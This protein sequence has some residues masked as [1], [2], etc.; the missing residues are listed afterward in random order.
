[1][2]SDVLSRSEAAARKAAVSDV[3][4]RLSLDLVAGAKDYSGVATV[5]FNGSADTFLEFLG[6]AIESM[7]INGVSQDP[8]WDGARIRLHATQLAEA[9]EITITYRKPYDHSGEGFHQF[10]DPNDGAEYLY[11]QFEPYGAHRLFP[12]FDQ[13][14]LKATYHLTVTAPEDWRIISSGAIATQ[15]PSSDGRIVTTFEET[16]PFSTYLF[17]VIAGAWN[18]VADDHNGLPMSLYTRRS[19]AEFID[20][21]ELFHITKAGMEFFGEF[22]GRRYPFTKYD[23]MFV[24]EFNW[25]G[26][27]NVAAV[28]YSDTLIFRDPP[29]RDQRVRRAE[30][31]LHELAHMWF[32]DLVTM[33]WWNDLWLNESFATFAAYLAIDDT[34]EWGESWQDFN[35][36]N[37]LTAYHD[38]QQ[39]T[40]H[41]IVAEVATTDE[42]FLNFDMITYGKGASTL[43]QLVAT[44]GLDAFSKGLQTYFARYE[45]RNTTLADFLGALQEGSGRQLAYWASRWLTTANLNTLEVRWE[46]SGDLVS[47]MTLH[48]SAPEDYPTL[49]PHTVEVGL[50]SESGGGFAVRGLPVTIDDLEEPVPAAVGAA[51][52]AA[53][54]PNY[55][56]LTYAKVA[57]DPVSLDFVRRSLRSIDDPLL[58]HQLWQSLWEM[59]RDRQ[60][61]SLD[62][63]D[64]MAA[65]LVEESSDQI[66]RMV[67]LTSGGTLA[68]FVPERVKDENVA[69]FVAMCRRA[70]DAAPAGDLKVL[71]ARSLVGAASSPQDLAM[72]AELVD[73]GADGLAVDQDMRWEVAVGWS[74]HG[75]T[76][77][78]ERVV[79]ELERD[80]TDRGERAA[81]RAE[82]GRP[83]AQV[84]AET[85][86]KLHRQGYD[87]L[88]KMRSAMTGFG[89]W[90]Q[91]D[92]LAPY[93]A[94]FFTRVEDVVTDWEWEGA[95]AYYQGLYPAYRVDEEN[96]ARTKVIRNAADPRLRRLATESV[97]NLERAQACRALAEA[98]L[99]PPPPQPPPPEDP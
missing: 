35:T 50:I 91:S 36:R 82:V 97:A 25:G 68:R 73:N 56:D 57:L 23:Q 12:C 78:A 96:L 13:P 66:I 88:A 33:E 62:Y 28:T 20:P 19:M 7:T 76:G 48:Q 22:F 72:A 8:E 87:S 34:G 58:R 51:V 26:M 39:P 52:P 21:D 15:E 9:N 71:W 59:V 65:H 83:D 3:S 60:L 4:Y 43:R 17:S 24:P 84:K 77:A 14:D 32:G 42:V 45:F 67:L 46:T 5:S 37:K 70:M 64:M 11:T 30:I 93:A 81:L 6:G 18:E 92:L 80:P 85:W 47:R 74:A 38:D 90:K 95:K 2:P 49:R 75:I 63:L 79:A 98:Q 54:F 94:E 29:T 86:E 89:W 41:P 53:V 10:F 27:E 44:I 61:S 55:N 31:L 16:L 69:E 1:M 40:T 99:D